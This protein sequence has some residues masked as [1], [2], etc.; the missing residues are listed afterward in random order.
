MFY[1]YI[2]YSPSINRFYIGFTKNMKD[3]LNRHNKHRSG[4]RRFTK[5]ASD[6]QLIYFEEFNNKRDAIKREKEIKNKKS[7]EYIKKLISSKN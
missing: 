4:F 7:K 5:R 2:L 6:W 1:V 3:I